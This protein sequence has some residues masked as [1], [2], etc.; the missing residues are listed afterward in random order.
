MNPVN[1]V[2]SWVGLR[3]SRSGPRVPPDFRRRFEDGLEACRRNGRGFTVL[4]ELHYDAGTHP[5][6]YRDFEC[7]FAAD[8]LARRRPEQILDVGSYRHFIMG[9]LA[10]TPV[11]TVDVRPREPATRSETVI[12]C[13]AKALAV[14]D[15]SFDAVVSLCAVEHVGLGRYGDDLDLDADR[16]AMAEMIRAL[17]PGGWLVF[18]TTVTRGAP[19][20]VFNAHRIY[21]VAMI[22]RLC[23]GLEKVE[24][25][26]FSLRARGPVSPA[27]VTT[28]PGVWDVYCG[29]WRKPV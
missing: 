19:A 20:I 7:A 18:S 29:A 23:A 12:V 2:L 13:D 9:L 14:P 25:R 3:V 17:R 10:A 11:T 15:A 21:D 4:R 16:A 26:F 28:E 8:C 1:R 22:E 6:T 5:A 24:E 27:E